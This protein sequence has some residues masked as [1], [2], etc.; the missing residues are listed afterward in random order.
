MTQK[1]VALITGSSRGIGRSCAYAISKMGFHIALHYRSDSDLAQQVQQEIPE[2]T[3]FQA[4][5]SDPDQC[6]NLIKEVSKKLGGLDALVNNAGITRDQMITFAKVGDFD[7]LINTNLKSVFLL[8][9]YASKIMIKK[10]SGN[11]VNLSSVVG[12]T[13]NAGQSIYSA[14]KSAISGFTK[15][16]AIDLARF[17]I[18]CNTVAPGFISTEMTEKF[19]GEQKKEIEQSIPL[20]KIGQPDD[21]AHAVAFLLSDKASYITGS[22]LHVNGGL[23]RN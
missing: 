21:V 16:V 17:N 9:K 1:K 6:L 19:D 2:S 13:G 20:G 3:I 8:T 7:S 5:L 11:I 22:T 15:S 18:R 4:D 14:T 23:F 10:K 12:H